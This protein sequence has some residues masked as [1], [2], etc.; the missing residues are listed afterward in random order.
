MTKDIDDYYTAEDDGLGE[1][2]RQA[3]DVAKLDEFRE[4]I[5]KYKVLCYK[6]IRL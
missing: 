6:D 2:V 1:L 4:V 3:Y 5:Q